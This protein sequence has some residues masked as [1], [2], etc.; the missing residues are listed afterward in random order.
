MFTLPYVTIILPLP[1][2]RKPLHCHNI[3]MTINHSYKHTFIH[4]YI[5]IT[6]TLP[7]P[8]TI[9]AL[10]VAGLEHLLFFHIL[11]MSSSQRT[12]IFSEGVKPPI[13]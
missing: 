12:F 7:L 1:Y 3:T 6:I 5:Q 11:G 2:Y 13:R 10:L 9:I 8:C 4:T